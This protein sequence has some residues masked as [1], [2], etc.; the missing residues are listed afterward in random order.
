MKTAIAIIVGTGVLTLT[1]GID[2]GM[3]A[4]KHQRHATHHRSHAAQVQAPVQQQG[5]TVGLATNG[6]NPAKRYPTRTMPD[7]AMKTSTLPGAGNNPAKSY[8]AR[9][10]AANAAREPTLYNKGNNPA[11]RAATVGSAR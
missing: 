2:S 3:A 5:E 7:G 11:K 9:Q 1:L 8:A 10:A 4:T 6:N